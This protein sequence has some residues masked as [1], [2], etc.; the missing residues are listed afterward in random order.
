M[1]NFFPRQRFY[2]SAKSC[3][4]L[5]L[6]LFLV[7]CITVVCI[8]Y[9]VERQTHQLELQLN[10]L[11]KTISAM[12]SQAI[13]SRYRQAEHSNHY[14]QR[15][16]EY[17][18]VSR[19]VLQRLQHIFLLMPN[20]IRL[21]SISIALD[22]WRLSADALQS[23]AIAAFRDQLLKKDQQ[24]KVTVSAVKSNSFNGVSFDVNGNTNANS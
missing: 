7:S 22:G 21:N 1:L 10:V 23:Q 2:H 14:Y 17:Y 12:N 6:V 24:R 13:K 5:V 19:I 8:C 18:R 16:R 9:Y 15:Y 4:L 11:N 20:N 3:Y